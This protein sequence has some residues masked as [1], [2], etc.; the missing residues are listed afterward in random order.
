MSTELSRDDIAE[1]IAKQIT[2]MDVE[3]LVV[4]IQVASIELGHRLKI[5][6]KGESNGEGD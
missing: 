5:N 3:A 1:R 6:D 4:L 2:M